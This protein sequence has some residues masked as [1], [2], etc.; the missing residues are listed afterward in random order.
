MN[1]TTKISTTLFEVKSLLDLPA[2]RT[3]LEALNLKPNFSKLAQSLKKDWRTVKRYYENGEPNRTR[4]KVSAIDDLKELITQLLSDEGP[5]IF[6]YKRILWQ[7]L[8]DNYGLAVAESTFRRYIA[9]HPEFQQYFE[10]NKRTIS[11]VNTIRYET[12]PGEQAQLDWKEDIRF[13]L[14]TGETMSF[15]VLVMNLSYSRFKVYVLTRNRTQATLLDAMTQMFETLGSVPSTILTDNMSTVMLEPRTQTRPGIV[16]TKMAEFATQFNFN[17]QPCIAGRPRTKGKVESQMKLLDEIHAYQGQ[18]DE[19]GLERL[20]QLINIRS[21]LL[22]SQ[23]TMKSPSALWEKEKESLRPLPSKAVR[24]SFKIHY[25]R[26]KVNVTHMVSVNGC[27]YSVPA[28]HVGKYVNIQTKEQYLYIY[29]NTELIA[30][31]ILSKKKLN[32][33][34]MHYEAHLRAISPYLS[35]DEIRIKAKENLAK[36]GEVYDIKD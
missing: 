9:N 33:L 7:Y 26:A 36:I 12:A 22:I 4:H 34:P 2:L 13:K 29:D 10:S 1:N 15:N 5:Q 23:T 24:D 11:S 3:R 30:Q 19:Q 8:K 14:I 6:Y 31:H 20:V 21:N 27:Q 17:I 18:L 25:L 35:K 16:H 32:Y 28:G